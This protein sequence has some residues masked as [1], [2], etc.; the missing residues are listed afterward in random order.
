VL[1]RLIDLFAGCGAMT[2]GFLD[3]GRFAPPLAVE[4]NPNAAATYAANFGGE[5]LHT[6]PI[7]EVPEFLA[8]EGLI[9][10]PPCQGFPH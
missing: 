8:A 3:T 2:R 1:Y 10:G 6:D 9:G 4:S 5:H 7:Q